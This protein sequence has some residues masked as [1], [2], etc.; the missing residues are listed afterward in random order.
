M[1]PEN[2]YTDPFFIVGMCNLFH[3][4][5]IYRQDQNQKGSI[6]NPKAKKLIDL[7]WEIPPYKE[8]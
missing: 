4:L 1:K 7:F 5:Q 6:G 3:Q 2:A 8:C